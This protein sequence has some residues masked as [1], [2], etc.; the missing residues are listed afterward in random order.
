MKSILVFLL[1]AVLA[2]TGCSA[3][4]PVK[5]VQGL[6][7]SDLIGIRFVNEHGVCTE[8]LTFYDLEKPD[9]FGRYVGYCEVYGPKE[10]YSEYGTWWIDS[11]GLLQVKGMYDVSWVE[12]CFEYHRNHPKRIIVKRIF[13]PEPSVFYSELQYDMETDYLWN[14]RYNRVNDLSILIYYGDHEND[15]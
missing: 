5:M 10:G 1:S 6:E 13:E 4:H 11:D 8:H 9:G 14:P 2:F 15:V 12:L 7:E 3:P